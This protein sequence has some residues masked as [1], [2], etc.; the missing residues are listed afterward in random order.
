MFVC[1]IGG[2]VTIN[3]DNMT[4]SGTTLSRVFRL[5]MERCGLLEEQVKNILINSVEA[6]FAPEEVKKYLLERVV[7]GE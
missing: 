4:V 2:K 1:R 5:V 7:S 6:T 3:A